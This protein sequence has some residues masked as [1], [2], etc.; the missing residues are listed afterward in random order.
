MSYNEIQRLQQLAGILT[1]IKVNNPI[2]KINAEKNNNW[3]LTYYSIKYYNNSWIPIEYFNSEGY[4]VLRKY[5]NNS[6]YS[7]ND[8]EKLNKLFNNKGIK[9]S[10]KNNLIFIPNKYINFK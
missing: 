8:K 1:E 10:I 6:I 3:G 2:Y 5:K 9:S 7:W 4:I